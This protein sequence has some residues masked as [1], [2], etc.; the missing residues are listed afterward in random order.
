MAR[1]DLLCPIC[2]AILGLPSWQ[3][4][5]NP[6]PAELDVGSHIHMFFPGSFVCSNGHRWQCGPD[7]GLVLTRI[8]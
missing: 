3:N 8:T 5:G 7:A 2:G 1:G 6:T 4:R